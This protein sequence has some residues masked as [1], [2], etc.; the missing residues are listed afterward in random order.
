MIRTQERLDIRGSTIKT[1]NQ[2][3]ITFSRF[4]ETKIYIKSYFLY[5]IPRGK[6]QQI[7]RIWS[8]GRSKIRFFVYLMTHVSICG[9]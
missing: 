9:K 4:E 5:N 6:Y 1:L 3:L 2:F 7:V 8:S